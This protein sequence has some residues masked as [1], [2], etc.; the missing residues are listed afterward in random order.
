[1]GWNYRVIKSER[2]DGTP[3]FSIHEVHYQDGVVNSWN[4]E[5][6]KLVSEDA[7]GLRWMLSAFTHGYRKSMLSVVDGKLCEIEPAVKLTEDHKD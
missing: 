4:A 6:A 5:P 7:G 1:M 2:P 3:V